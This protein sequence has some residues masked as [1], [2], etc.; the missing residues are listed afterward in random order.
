[1][2]FLSSS[3]PQELKVVGF[4]GISYSALAT[5]WGFEQPN[6]SGPSRF[7]QLDR[8]RIIFES[9]SDIPHTIHVWYIYLHL[10]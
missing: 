9:T 6:R 7:A 1:M 10:A 4:D 2:R 8:F 3:N 5:S